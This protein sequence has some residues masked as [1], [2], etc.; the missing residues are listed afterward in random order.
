MAEITIKSNRGFT[1]L[2]LNFN[3]HPTTKDI[4]KFKNEN[5]VINSVKKTG[6]CVVTHEAPMT[7]G[8]GAELTSKI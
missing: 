1:D 8:F 6:K 3:I 7:C 4:N 2:D 5:A